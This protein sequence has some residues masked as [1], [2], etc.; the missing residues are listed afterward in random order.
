MINYDKGYDNVSNK[1]RKCYLKDTS[2]LANA[3]ASLSEKQ[4]S[5][6]LF[7]SVCKLTLAKVPSLRKNYL[8]N[9]YKII[10]NMIKVKTF[11]GRIKKNIN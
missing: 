4:F 9:C 10:K 8:S 1:N 2:A 3:E 11:I 7:A 6:S 5:F